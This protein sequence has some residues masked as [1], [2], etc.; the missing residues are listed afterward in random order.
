MVSD[1]ETYRLA[2]RN[3]LFPY[4]IHVVSDV[5]TSFIVYYNTMLLLGLDIEICIEGFSYDLT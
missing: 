3:I 4:W 5:E 1:V 2:L